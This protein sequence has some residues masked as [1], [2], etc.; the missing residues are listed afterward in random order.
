MVMPKAGDACDVA[1]LR[2]S[3]VAPAVNGTHAQ[4]SKAAYFRDVSERPVTL[5]DGT[6]RR[7]DPNTLATWESRYRRLGF[8]GLT[9]SGRSDAGRSRKIGPEAEAAIRALREAHPKTSCVETGLRPVADGTIDASDFSDSTPR[10]S[11]SD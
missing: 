5:P 10:R 1:M 6:V 11:L 2:F 4:P 9:R 8:D 3:P 7:L